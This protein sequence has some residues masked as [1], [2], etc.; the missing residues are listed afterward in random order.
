MSSKTF[1]CVVPTYQRREAVRRLL[2]GF[3][4]QLED[5]AAAAGVDVLVIVDGST[6]G[7]R[8]L[9]ENLCYP[10]PV[11]VIWQENAGLAAARNRGLESARGDVVWFLDDDMLLAEGVLARHRR[12]HESGPERLLVGPC[13][14][15]PD[16]PMVPTI[17]RWAEHQYATLARA[18]AVEDALYFSAANTS[19]PTGLW[20]RV[21]GFAEN[22]P[23]WG[24]EDYELGLRL[25]GAGVPIAYDADAVVWH[26]QVRSVAG[27]CANTRDQGRNAVRIVHLHPEALDDLFPRASADRGLRVLRR[28]CGRSAAAHRAAATLLTIAAVAEERLTCGHRQGALRLARAANRLAGSVELDREGR[29]VRRLFDAPA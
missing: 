20:R 27:F 12:A 13:L 8:E 25:L 21:G 10:M 17:R 19:G 2:D 5:P 1:T 9:L 3:A 23:G 26:Q 22:L 14:P 18:G 29:F 15:P 28:L 24:G 16:R 4:A 7:T 6:D 11:T